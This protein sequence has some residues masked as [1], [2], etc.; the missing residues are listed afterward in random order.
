M[1]VNEALLGL[2]TVTGLK[3][4]PDIRGAKDGENYIVFTYAS[5]YPEL[6][7]DDEVE[8]DTAEI[9]VSLYTEPSY[10]YMTLKEQIKQYLESLDYCIVTSV[11]SVLEDYTTNTNSVKYKRHTTFEVEITKWRE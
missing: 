2:E 1:N 10:D 5:E 11:G 7:S 6:A 9:Y 8:A 4:R 3:V